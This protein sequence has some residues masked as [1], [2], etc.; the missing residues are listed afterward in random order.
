MRCQGFEENRK[1]WLR[2]LRRHVVVREKRRKQKQ[3]KKRHVKNGLESQNS[4]LPL[5]YCSEPALTAAVRLG[6]RETRPLVAA[7]DRFQSPSML[8]PS[9]ITIHFKLPCF[10]SVWIQKAVWGSLTN[11]LSSVVPTWFSVSSTW[12]VIN[13]SPSV[14]HLYHI[15]VHKQRKKYGLCFLNACPPYST[16]CSR[17]L[18]YLSVLWVCYHCSLGHRFLSPQH[19]PCVTVR[20]Y[21][22][23]P[24]AFHFTVAWTLNGSLVVAEINASSAWQPLVPMSTCLL[25]AKIRHGVMYSYLKVC[26]SRSTPGYTQTQEMYLH[27]RREFN[28]KIIAGSAR[29]TSTVWS[30][31]WQSQSKVK[32]TPCFYF[33]S[34]KLYIIC[35]LS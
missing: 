6:G 30:Q 12:L 21:V 5:F 25:S 22:P 20:T 34:Q 17:F 23:W 13:Y 7:T 14:I 32:E 1:R 3:N 16:W 18:Y 35:L 11:V 26:L 10:S 31:W 24:I 28:R 8:C 15:A 29:L 27:I 4:P 19:H 2:F 9:Q 33:Q